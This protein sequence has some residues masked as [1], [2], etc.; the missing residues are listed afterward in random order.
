MKPLLAGGA[1]VVS[2]ASAAATK[3]G[4]LDLATLDSVEDYSATRVYGDA[5]LA[6]I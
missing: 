2:T 4:H 3:Y 1:T 5:K 6:T